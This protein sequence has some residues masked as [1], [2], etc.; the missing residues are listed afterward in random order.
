MDWPVSIAVELA[1]V[2]RIRDVKV[3]WRGDLN[4]T[5]IAPI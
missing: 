2:R 4:F 5:V 3:I 1:T